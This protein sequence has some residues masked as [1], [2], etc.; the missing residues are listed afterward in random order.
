MFQAF[1]MKIVPILSDLAIGWLVHSMVL[2]LGGRRRVA[3]LAADSRSLNPISWFDSVVWGQVDSV[4]VVFML[5]ALRELWRDRPERAAI[6]TVVA[7]IIKPQLGDPHP[8]RRRRHDPAGVVARGRWRRSGSNRAPD[9]DPHDGRRGLHHG[10]RAVPARS[11]SRSSRFVPQAPFLRSGL[12]NQVA[13]AAGGYPYLTVNAFNLWALVPSD[14]G[15]SLANAGFWVCDFSGAGSTSAQAARYCGLNGTASIGGIPPVLIGSVLLLATVGLILW[16]VA[17]RPDRE[18]LL[19][20]LAA[21]ALAFFVVPTRVHERYGYPFFAVGAI[22]AAISLRWRAAYV[23]LS[24]ATLA[25]M[26]VVLTTFYPDNPSIADWFGI[27]PALKS[28][29]GVA[30]VAVVHTIAF[31]WVVVQLRRSAVDRVAAALAPAAT[32]VDET[33]GRK[34]E[35]FPGWIPTPP[36]P[37]APESEPEEPPGD[38]RP[39]RRRGATAGPI[40]PWPP[41]PSPDARRQAAS[42]ASSAARSPPGVAGPPSPSSASWA[43]S[44]RDSTAPPIRPD[45]SRLLAGEGGGRLDRL[46]LWLLVVLVVA[47]LFLRTFRLAEPYQMHFDEVYHARTATEFLQDW[48]YGIEHDIYEWT[49]PHLAKYA[50]AAGLVLWGGD[51]VRATSDLGVPVVAAVIEPRRAS[52]GSPGG[53]TTERLHVATGSEIRTYD[54]ATRVLRSVV[55]APGVTALAWDPT[56]PAADPGVRRRA[57]GHPRCDDARRRRRRHRSRAGRARDRR[58]SRRPADRGGRWGDDRRGVRRSPEPRRPGL[59]QRD[60]E[61]RLARHRG[62]RPG[63][64]G[65]GA[66]GQRGGRHRPGRPSPRSWP[67]CS[68][69]RPTTTSRS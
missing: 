66:R 63:R 9:P 40:T 34:S 54:L 52:A 38:D 3:L 64:F 18:T 50:M 59:G 68:A 26:Y 20:G 24:L 35:P 39:A 43:G 61:R 22:L 42:T 44:G 10:G 25:N 56:G 36:V 32:F 21:L 49:H 4:G 60:R 41:Y 17:R 45:R 62:P 28:S 2:E 48:R 30:I 29:T 19:V 11:A 65:P 37:S 51:A 8:A 53:H 5:L 27:G 16:L 14:V 15:T 57:S 58:P 12:L 13:V 23:A 67:T 7:A 55:Q 31:I 46:D 1:G 6:W 69:R 47:S 33:A